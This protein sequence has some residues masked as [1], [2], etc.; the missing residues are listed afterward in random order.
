MSGDFKAMINQWV[1]ILKLW[2]INAMGYNFYKHPV[3]LSLIQIIL[4]SLVDYYYFMILFSDLII[5][6]MKDILYHTVGTIPR[7]NG[8]IVSVY[9]CQDLLAVALL[10]LLFTPGF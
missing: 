4:W 6:E 8:K 1:G 10:L 2:Y 7:F 3:S 5:N 9:L